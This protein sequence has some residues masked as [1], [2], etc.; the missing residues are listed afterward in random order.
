MPQPIFLKDDIVR[1]FY[2]LSNEKLKRGADQIGFEDISEKEGKTLHHS[3]YLL[4]VPLEIFLSNQK[5]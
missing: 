3:Y 4:I 5:I 2:V 1:Y